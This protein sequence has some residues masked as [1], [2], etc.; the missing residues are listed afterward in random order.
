M[1]EFR[2]GALLLQKCLKNVPNLTTLVY[3]NGWPSDNSVFEGVDAVVIYSDG[4]GG[5]PAIQGE[6]LK[7]LQGLIDKGWFGMMHDP[8]KFRQIKAW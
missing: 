2:A 7:F 6:R 1:H 8:V 4:G 3:S 5:H